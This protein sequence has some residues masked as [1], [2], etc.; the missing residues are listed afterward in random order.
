MAKSTIETRVHMLRER[1]AEM[2]KHEEHAL[3]AAA[4]EVT[5]A[6]ERWLHDITQKFPD[7]TT[8]DV[9]SGL[10]SISVTLMGR[11]LDPVCGE[12]IDKR[13]A[14]LTPMLDMIYEI[15]SQAP[16][17]RHVDFGFDVKIGGIN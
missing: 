2:A 14:L 15:L 8:E 11:V 1:Y 3:T 5:V 16:S 13:D 12:D 7:A 9:L 6:F 17:T 4:G 10:L